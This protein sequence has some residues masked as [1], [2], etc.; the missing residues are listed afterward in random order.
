MLNFYSTP[1]AI[2]PDASNNDLNRVSSVLRYEE[3]FTWVFLEM[4]GL[5]VF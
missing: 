2:N 4:H 5:A 3:D 1:D